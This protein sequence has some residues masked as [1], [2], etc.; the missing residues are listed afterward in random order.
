VLWQVV[1]DA[2]ADGRG[3]VACLVA[4]E[5]GHAAVEALYD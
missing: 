3:Q 1:V 2:R 5:R 4:V